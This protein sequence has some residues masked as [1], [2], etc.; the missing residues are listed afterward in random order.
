MV[1]NVLVRLMALVAVL[2]PVVAVAA[3]ANGAPALEKELA[4]VRRA[5]AKYHDVEKA[6]ADGYIA[7]PHCVSVPGLGGMGYHYIKPSLATD[8][9]LDPLQPEL[10]LYAP[11]GNGLRLV[12]VEYF[13]ANVGQEHPE[14][15]GIPLHGPMPGHE[16]GMPEHYDLH[17]WIWQPN[18]NGMFV[19]FNPNVSCEAAG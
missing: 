14:V 3:P 12:A 10:L 6:L 4:A 16:A 19:D 1:F 15:M 2:S 5:T 9:A 17:A 18:P 8:L 13:V 11:S 7:A